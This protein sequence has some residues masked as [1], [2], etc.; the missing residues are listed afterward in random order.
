M[1]RVE[2]RSRKRA[3]LAI[4]VGDT[5]PTEFRI[6]VKGLNPNANGPA[7]LFDDQAARDVMAVYAA[8]GVDRMIDLEHL[9]L[10]DP[11]K[12][13]NYDPDARG[14]CK[15]E[16]RPDGSLWAVNV[17]WTPDGEARLRDKRQRYISPAFGYDPAT[18]R[19]SEIVNIAVTALPATYGTLPLMAA[20]AQR[21]RDLRKLSRGSSFEDVFKALDQALSDRYANTD[22]YYCSPWICDVFDETVVFQFDGKL[23]ELA[24]VF[25]GSTATLGATPTEVKRDYSPVAPTSPQAPAQQNRKTAKHAVGGTKMDP[26]KIA[27]LADALGL[28]TDASYEDVIAAMAAMLKQ[29]QASISGDAEP[30][31]ADPKEPKED[32]AGEAPAAAMSRLMRLSAKPTAKQALEEVETWR[33]SHIELESQRAQLALERKALESAER[34]SLVTRLVTECGEAPATA[35]ADCDE[36]TPSKPAAPW[37]DMPLEAL[38]ARVAKLSGKGAPKSPKPPAGGGGNGGTTVAD[39]SEDELAK[40]R[41]KNIDPAKYAEKKAQL[42]ARRAR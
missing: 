16:V 4:S 26:T 29:L 32:P 18:M 20:R 1:N 40:C 3:T 19:I 15:L 7:H 36:K 39:L 28:G 25:D 37:A 22:P 11:E 42:A 34:R 24:Y 30:D 12:S 38:R 17:T 31:P 6:F 27:A 14:W 2:G 9:S 8:H 21:P 33:K 41:A 35:W 5:L 23:F 10:E 13:A